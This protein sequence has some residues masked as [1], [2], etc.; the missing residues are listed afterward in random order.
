MKVEEQQT[1]QKRI[2]AAKPIDL[3]QHPLFLVVGTGRCGSTLLHSMLGANEQIAMAFETSFFIDLD[4]VANGFEDP[5]PQDQTEAYLASLDRRFEKQKRRYDPEILVQYYRAVREGMLDARSQLGWV[6]GVGTVGQSGRVIGE[7]SPNHWKHIERALDIDPECKV[8]HLVRDPRSVTEALLRMPWWSNK[9]VID[10]ATYCAQTLGSCAHWDS[11]LSDE[12][13]LI[14]R[15]EDLI[16]NPGPELKR[17]C[18]FLDVD[19]QQEMSGSYTEA[20]NPENGFDRRKFDW[21]KS[22]AQKLNELKLVEYREKLT[23]SE[24]A[25][26]ESVITPQVMSRYGYSLCSKR[27]ERGSARVRRCW[28]K[29]GK[30][31]RKQTRSVIKRLPH[32]S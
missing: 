29:A 4:P 28:I 30:F 31:F 9:S 6:L 5:I 24:V 8:V 3:S 26:I 7:K 22:S 15:F 18:S 11:E 32:R 14:V 20:Q 21:H 19:Y 27:S 25:M 1:S 17:I 13:H 2:N 23:E 10:T 16:L 12:Q